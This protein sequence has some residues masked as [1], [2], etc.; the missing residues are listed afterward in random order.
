ML[1]VTAHDINTVLLIALS[2]Q[3]TAYRQNERVKAELINKL[4][5]N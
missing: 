2:I 4:R 1:S 5:I 3:K